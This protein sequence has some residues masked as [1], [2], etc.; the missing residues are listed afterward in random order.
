MISLYLYIL[1]QL[2]FLSEKTHIYT[3]IHVDHFI[4]KTASE[5]HD[6]AQMLYTV[7]LVNIFFFVFPEKKKNSQQRRTYLKTTNKTLYNVEETTPL[8]MIIFFIIRLK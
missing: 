2:F 7:H 6:D 8:V 4:L 1:L 3:L 5:V